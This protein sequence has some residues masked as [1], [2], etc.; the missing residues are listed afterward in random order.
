VR[1]AGLVTPASAPR[2]TGEAWLAELRAEIATLRDRVAIL[3]GR[4]ADTRGLEADI[5]DRAFLVTIAA[6]VHNHAFSAAELL[7]H[8]HT[9]P[10]LAAAVGGL[11]PQQIG[12]RL[13]AA[14]VRPCGD[15]VL[16]R[17]DRDAHGTI[18]ALQVRGALT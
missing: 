6:A 9:D 11:T 12:K 4:L 14:A 18:W 16:E 2:L 7:A 5:R 15:L 13:Q 8:A 17:V 10:E 3:E 1:G